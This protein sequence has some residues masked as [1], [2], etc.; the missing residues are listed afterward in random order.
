M[1]CF[2][3]KTN[4]NISISDSDIDWIEKFIG[5]DIHFDRARR[6]VIKSLHRPEIKDV[7]AF[8]GTGKT[9]MLVAK[10]GILAAKW[11]TQTKGMCVLSYTNVARQEIQ[12]RL[13][14]SPVG[15]ILFNPPHFIGTLHAFFGE[16]VAEPWLRSKGKKITC[17]DD[18]ITLQ[19][20]KKML[21]SSFT[22]FFYHSNKDEE[23]ALKMLQFQQIKKMRNEVLNETTAT[24]QQASRVIKDSLNQGFYTFSELLYFANMALK[25]EPLISHII[26]RRFPIVFIDEAQDT[27][28]FQESLIQNAFANSVIQR[29]GDRNQA[30]YAQ[31]AHSKTNE[32]MNVYNV[33]D[34]Q[35][36]SPVTVAQ[37]NP[38]TVTENKMIGCNTKYSNVRNTII[39]FKPD[40]I[41][42]VLP[43]FASLVLKN[44]TDKQ[45]HSKTAY[46]CFAVGRVTQHSNNSQKHF[47]QEVRDYFPAFDRDKDKNHIS[48]L[49][50][51]ID[52]F[53]IAQKIWQEQGKG[54]FALREII[55]G[56]LVV[57]HLRTNTWSPLKKNLFENLRIGMISDE[58]I[59]YLRHVIRNSIGESIENLEVWQ[60]LVS[61][62]K[63]FWSKFGEDSS[64]LDNFLAW[65]KQ[66]TE[67]IITD[68]AEDRLKTRN[69]FRYCEGPRY[70]N[71]QIS[72]IHGVKGQT[73]LA[74]LVLETFYRTHDLKNILGLLEGT[75]PSTKINE[76]RM[77]INYV[78]MTRATGM[79]GLALPKSELNSK[80]IT[81]LM[82]QGWE[83]VDC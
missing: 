80:D 48:Q 43:A 21:G 38:L 46:D 31:A 51:L 6:E 30:I 20:R 83:I 64:A 81:N 11:P 13:G 34:S 58:D 53:Y 35:R 68:D 44:F 12:N 23:A 40:S 17:I 49:S 7:Q 39:L 77:R 50:N 37:V 69:V 65:H 71:I 55:N 26:T 79:L 76:D 1:N 45:L 75:T 5:N 9:T 32:K 2:D 18:D 25:N 56:L 59:I 29:F 33:R 24:Y 16:Y 52:Y 73:H 61:E 4:C 14:N 28:Q 42:H 78:A 10:L 62:L 54:Y 70:L 72:S 74:T 15:G 19:K 36:L 66:E 60:G 47:P 27:S 8:P 22:W 67:L 63:K 57:V 41:Q 82:H 3:G